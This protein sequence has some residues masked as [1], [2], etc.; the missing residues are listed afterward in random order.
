[1]WLAVLIPIL[2]IAAGGIFVV[3]Q[4]ASSPGLASVGVCFAI[5]EFSEQ[6]DPEKVDCTDPSANV[7]LAV[8]LD[9]ATATCPE[10]DY[11]EL[12]TTGAGDNKLCLTLNV[13]KGD[14]VANV[15]ATPRGTRR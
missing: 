13:A 3:V 11:D 10:G 12:S 8:K 6:T 14:C 1:V 15:S 2:V 9:S 4:F 7:K 5:S